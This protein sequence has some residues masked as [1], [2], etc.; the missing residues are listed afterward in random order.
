M[1]KSVT[2]KSS[3]PHPHA[4]V[5]TV[6]HGNGKN[7]VCASSSSGNITAPT[8]ARARVTV[9]AGSASLSDLP[10]IFGI[11]ELRD[12][13]ARAIAAATA[14]ERDV[15]LVSPT[16]SGKTWAFTGAGLIR[17]GLT[18]IVCPLRSLIADLHR[19][20][21]ELDIPVR[22]WN[23]DVRDKYKSETLRLLDASWSGF[24][25][26]TPESL[27]G[28]EFRQH[29]IGAVNLVVI[30]EAHSALRERG[31]R[32]CYA[33]LG[34]L[35]DEIRP[36]RRFACTA[37]LPCADQDK[38][39]EVLRLNDLTRIIAPVARSNLSIR[40]V[41]RDKYEL[42][43]VL[44]RHRGESGIIFAATRRTAKQLHGELS[45]QGRNV[46]VYHG[47]LS[48]KA[49]KQ[50][51]ADFMSGEVP[52][53]IATD[54]FIL[55]ID[56]SDI[57]FIVHYDPPKSIEDWAQGFGRAGRDELPANVYGCFGAGG[58]EGFR[59]R[60]FLI[61]ATFSPVSDLRAVWS[62]I[63]NW[64]H[65]DMRA[66]RIGETVLGANGKYSGPAILST[67]QRFHLLEAKPHPEDGRRRLY[68]ARGDFDAAPWDAYSDEA[69]EALDRLDQLAELV[70]LPEAKM[71]EAI[72]EYFGDAAI[73]P[74]P[75]M[76]MMA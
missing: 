75:P 7:L 19:R 37:T 49:K 47:K 61:K 40:I 2:A 48:A 66:Q 21:A 70:Q 67:L 3:I 65:V 59:T 23:S 13:Q 25:I 9:T 16:G 35:I 26:T 1:S 36:Q 64:P 42:I 74:A 72:E 50:A 69:R 76:R 33:R 51:Q 73:P 56:K 45:A 54:A 34:A 20:L 14:S 58:R 53:A 52:V 30:D 28:R 17:G 29:L 10:S 39:V 4:H 38:L 18:L 15:L 55:G 44:N 57:R 22:I 62:Y 12:H 71:P 63:H 60:R 43:D 24:L 27:K 32:H 31:F 6:G 5:R 11:S 8:Y 41:R 68:S 46:T